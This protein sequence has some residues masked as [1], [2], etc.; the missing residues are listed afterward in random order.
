MPSEKLHVS[1]QNAGSDLAAEVSPDSTEE[2]T[3]CIHLYQQQTSCLNF[4]LNPSDHGAFIPIFHRKFAPTD[5]VYC[6]SPQYR[7]DT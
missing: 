5:G 1:A 7:P 4:T 2:L 6:E 3:V